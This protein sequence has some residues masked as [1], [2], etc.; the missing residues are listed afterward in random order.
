MIAAGNVR[1]RFRMI[2]EKKK[3]VPRPSSLR[4]DTSLARLGNMKFTERD[5]T[6]LDRRIREVS[7]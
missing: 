5:I 2:P 1:Y 6:E 3:V 7:N 4:G